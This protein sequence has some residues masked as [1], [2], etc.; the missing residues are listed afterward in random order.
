MKDLFVFISLTLSSLLLQ[1]QTPCSNPGQTASTAFPVCGTSVFTQNTVPVCG[2]FRLPSPS[3]AT[4]RTSDKNP[5]WYKFTCFKSGTLG[6]LVTPKDMNSDYDWELYDVTGKDPNDAYRDGSLVIASNWSGEKGLTGAS[7]SGTQRF[8][9]AGFGK[10]LFSSMPSLVEGHNYILLISH[11]S[12]TQFGYD[13]SFGGGTAVITDPAIPRLAK[14]EA[15]CGGS[16]ISIKLSKKI[17]CNSIAANG[18]DFIVTPA[19]SSPVKGVSVDCT[20]KFDTDSITITLSQNLPPGNY[21]LGMK[22]GDDGNTLLDYCDHAVPLTDVAT[23]SVLP[24]SPTPMDSL[25]KPT[26]SPSSLKLIFSE[27]ISCASL[28]AN[29]SDFIL[30]GPYTVAIDNATGI[31]ANGTSFTRE[32]VLAL[33]QPLQRNGSFTLA[34]KNGSDGNTLLNHCGVPT[35]AG[36]SISFSIRDTVNADFAYNIQYGCSVDM[37]DFSHPGGNGVTQWKWNLDDNQTGSN[38]DMQ[39]RYQVFEEKHI[40][41]VVSNGFCSDTARQTILLDN[42]LKAD[43]NVLPDHCHSEPVGFKSTSS[44][45]ITRHEWLFGDGLSG[46]GDSVTH[47]Y[48]AP[49][50]TTDYT[51]R[52][53]VTDLYGCT[54]T[55]EKPVKI[56]VNCQIDVPN[57]FTPDADMK[58]D[59][60]YPLNAIKAEQLDFKVFNR[61]GQLIFHSNDWKKGWDGRFNGQLQPPGTYVWTLQYIHRDTKQKVQKKG[62]SLLVR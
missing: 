58:N 11:F 8:V 29:G 32:I 45:K 19:A 48:G 9:C 43:F 1:A 4:D 16:T 10:P 56:Y 51:V 54:K 27:P 23:F 15:H 6:F 30:N 28:A 39:G 2:D 40:E 18:S 24:V 59:L 12:N 47:V 3:C 49:P 33:S 42:F 41:L 44:G 38:Q 26:C 20:T 53:T 5:F 52:H 17:K 57:A 31:C 7:A 55:I 36:S 25:V 34:L 22:A 50:G 62:T 61:W 21:S 60:L 46:N 37:V 35:P 14:A 13:L